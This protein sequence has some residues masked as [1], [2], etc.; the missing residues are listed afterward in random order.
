MK[1]LALIIMALAIGSQCYAQSKYPKTS[2][3]VITTAVDT[4]TITGNDFQAFTGYITNTSK[5]DTLAY[6]TELETTWA[7]LLPR[8]AV[9]FNRFAKKLFRKTLSGS[10]YSQLSIGQITSLGSNVGT[11]TTV[12]YGGWY[13]TSA[14][15]HIDSN[16]T[17]S[18]TLTIP[19]G[20]RLI[21]LSVP[22][23]LCDTLRLNVSYLG[24]SSPLTKFYSAAGTQFT[25]KLDSSQI[26][27]IYLPEEVGFI[28]RVSFVTNAACG[29]SGG[30]LVTAIYKKE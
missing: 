2:D 16:A 12:T 25:V 19:S 15:A 20:S 6:R 28:R 5:T 10:A 3:K 7:N 22:S 18:D 23:G 1:K 8:Q 13:L 27:Q 14:T 30:L 11:D 26:N 29:V 9:A 24:L 4:L 17:N 21:A